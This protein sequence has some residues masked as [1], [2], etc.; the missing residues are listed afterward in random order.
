MLRAT[1]V[2]VLSAMCLLSSVSRAADLVL[3]EGGKSDYRIVLADKASPSTKH[4][5]EEL[6]AFLAQMTGAKLPIV[7][8]QQPLA[9]HE[10]I[11]GDNAHLRQIGVKVDF[12]SLGLEGYVIQTV[13]DRLVIAGGQLRG[14]LYGVYGLLEDHLGCRWFTPTVSRI[15]KLARLAVGAINDRQVPSLEYREPFISECFDADWCARNRMNSNTAPLEAKHGGKVKYLSLAHSFA[16]LVPCDQYFKDHPEY[17]SMIDG[18]RKSGETQLCCTNPD[19]VRIC[20]EAIRQEM[21]ANP[22]VTAFTVSQNDWF[23]YCECPKCQALAK[24]EGSQMAPVLQLVNSV[25]EALEK[26]FP[27]KYVE[28]LAY[29]WTRQPPKN[30]RPR[31]NVLVMLC[32]I[33]CC[34]SHPL[35]T[36]NSDESKA[37]RADVEAWAKIAPRLWVW[38]YTTDFREYLLP[39]PNHHVVSPNIQFYAAHHVTGIFEEDTYDTPQGELSELDGYV[40]AKC[41]WNPN[42]DPNRATAEFLDAYYGPAAAAIHKYLDLLQSHVNDNN[43]HVGTYA[44]T[45]HPFLTDTLLTKGN[46][47]W[48]QAEEAVAAQPDLLRRVKLSRMSIDYAIVERG[49]AKMTQQPACNDAVVTLAKQRFAPF[50]ETLQSSSV[51]RLHES[52]PL[53][54]EVYRRDLAAALQIK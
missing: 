54:K 24:Q 9:A 21:K 42:Y 13:G 8:D 32:S 7:S 3:A 52:Q 18:K 10:I 49:R 50:I 38:D 46:E 43:I 20:T 14:N 27:G 1:S 45:D 22:D 25:A 41:L 34:F 40:M 28:T 4:A 16:T 31:Q 30:I 53:D 2:F 33:E 37:F 5:A 47:L 17:F 6:Q 48:R 51:A 39:Y 11:L 29:Q 36:C 44:P 26:E 23:S 35:A 15:P 12:K 19:V